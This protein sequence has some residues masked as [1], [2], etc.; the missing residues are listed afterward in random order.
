MDASPANVA[1]ATPPHRFV[2][3]LFSSNDT[4]PEPVIGVEHVESDDP[5][6]V[7]SRH[8]DARVVTE[9]IRLRQCRA[10]CSNTQGDTHIFLSDR[11]LV[12]PTTAF[13]LD[14][15]VCSL[16]MCMT[17][18]QHGKPDAPRVL[19]WLWQ[20]SVERHNPCLL[21]FQNENAD[22]L[23][24]FADASHCTAF[25]FST[26]E[27]AVLHRRSGVSD[28]LGLVISGT[29]R[30][31]ALN[32]SKTWCIGRRA[33]L[34]DN[35]ID[36][37]VESDHAVYVPMDNICAVACLAN[38]TLFITATGGFRVPS[39]DTQ[40]D[41]DALPAGILLPLDVQSRVWIRYCH[42]R[43]LERQFALSLGGALVVYDQAGSYVNV[44][45]AML[46]TSICSFDAHSPFIAWHTALT[47]PPMPHKRPLVASSPDENACSATPN[48]AVST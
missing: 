30:I 19:V 5:T 11:L 35:G 37:H 36:I 20:A 18:R 38:I 27:R 43:V 48:T 25:L 41:L 24:S 7:V 10:I 26:L 3:R 4:H 8:S 9:M 28:S 13:M 40:C 21:R 1:R 39:E 23:I 22:I 47:V 33:L 32:E 46:H 16:G 34:Q 15:A 42:V 12:C 31:I 14:L 45:E 29:P 2:T 17:Q 6:L 44:V